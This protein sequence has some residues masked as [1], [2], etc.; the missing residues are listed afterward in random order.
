MCTAKTKRYGGK[1][2]GRDFHGISKMPQLTGYGREVHAAVSNLKGEFAFVLLQIELRVSQVKSGHCNNEP[3]SPCVM[4]QAWGCTVE[5]IFLIGSKDPPP[6][7]IFCG[8]DGTSA[9]PQISMVTVS[10]R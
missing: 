1:G 7:F 9:C 8:E 5:V 6:W 2:R 10:L 4:V 3:S